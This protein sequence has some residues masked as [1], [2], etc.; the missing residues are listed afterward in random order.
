MH[1]T[2]DMMPVASSSDLSAHVLLVD[3]DPLIRRA[4][5][6]LLRHVGHT[7]E[8]HGDGEAALSALSRGGFDLVLTDVAMPQVDG[9]TLLRRIRQFDAELPV[10]LMTGKPELSS[11]VTAVELGAQRYLTKP[12]DYDT[13]RSTVER[14]AAGAR[15]NRR[16]R[17]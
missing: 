12:F 6:R 11:A 2:G 14:A 15:E 16:W 5:A 8:E 13:L 9:L 7:V 10:I 1:C 4:T 17:D 3:D